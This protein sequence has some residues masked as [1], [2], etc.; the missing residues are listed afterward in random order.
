MTEVHTPLADHEADATPHFICPACGYV[1]AMTWETRPA[2]T[3]DAFFY[4]RGKVLVA[5]ARQMVLQTVCLHP[6]GTSRYGAVDDASITARVTEHSVT[7]EAAQE[8]LTPLTPHAAI[9]S[10]K[11]IEDALLLALAGPLAENL[12]CTV[13]PQDY[14]E[15][16]G[17]AY[18]HLLDLPD[19]SP[20]VA[21]ENDLLLTA[22]QHRIID[23]LDA[24]DDDLKR[25]LLGVLVERHILT[26][27]V[28]QALMAHPGEAQ[29]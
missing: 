28:I 8:M 12:H 26:P 4:A 6:D 15:E 3:P 16:F 18:D 14:P 2:K 13:H 23:I 7:P 1:C 20:L 19:T 29:P 10:P 21:D 5:I 9:L 25:D 22:T 27:A 11:A 17:H 24:A